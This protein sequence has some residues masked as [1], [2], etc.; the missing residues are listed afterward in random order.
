MY[1]T[2][3]IRS[4]YRGNHRERSAE[5]VLVPSDRGKSLGFLPSFLRAFPTNASAVFVFET[6]MRILK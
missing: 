1:R 5:V 2:D 3:G 6:V 4:F